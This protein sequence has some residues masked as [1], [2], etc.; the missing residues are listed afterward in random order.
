MSL[1]STPVKRVGVKAADNY[2]S[3]RELCS[4]QDSA[5]NQINEAYVAPKFSWSKPKFSESRV[6]KLDYIAVFAEKTIV[7]PG[8]LVKI[9]A[10]RKHTVPGPEHYDMIK[11]WSKKPAMD[12]ERQRGKQYHR[13]RI[14]DTEAII[15]HVKRE[16]LPAPNKYKPNRLSRILGPVN[17]K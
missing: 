15:K 16:A 8:K 1:Q 14:T 5:L 17:S 10:K 4:G 11:D 9:F 3:V 7:E 6:K 13:D 12:Y 2:I